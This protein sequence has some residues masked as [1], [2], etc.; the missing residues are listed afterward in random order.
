M[1]AGEENILFQYSVKK[2]NPD[3]VTAEIDYDECKIIR[4]GDAFQDDPHTSS[5]STIITN[6]DLSLLPDDNEEFNKH[7][8]RSTKKIKDAEEILRKQKEAANIKLVDN[9]A[10]ISK[11]FNEGASPYELLFDEF[12]SVGSLTEHKVQQ[13][14][15]AGKITYK[16]LW[17]KCL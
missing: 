14:K 16:Q 9:T 6:Y 8:G 15:N 3:C 17:S 4:G 1:P 12:E 7:L 11:K 5:E 10:D 13:G 2:I